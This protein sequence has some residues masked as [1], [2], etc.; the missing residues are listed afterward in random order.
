MRH[1]F[2]GFGTKWGV[3]V[4]VLKDMPDNALVAIVDGRDVLLNIHKDDP[5]QGV[6]IRNGF[7]EA[8]K[9]LTHDKPGAV[10]MS[11]EGQCCVAA[12]TFVKPGDYFFEDGHEWKLQ[13][14]FTFSSCLT[15]SSS[16]NI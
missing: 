6:D 7:V 10:V 5:K 16:I 11:T 8:H 3:V 9:A 1:S 13:P 15:F 4:P 2:E 14:D 12:M